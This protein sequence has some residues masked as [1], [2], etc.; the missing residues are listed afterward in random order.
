MS[1]EIVEENEDDNENENEDEKIVYT[2]VEED[3]S[4]PIDYTTLMQVEKVLG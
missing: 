1:Y 3:H 4:N 2:V